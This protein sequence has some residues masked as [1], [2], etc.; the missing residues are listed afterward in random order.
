MFTNILGSLSYQLVAV[1]VDEGCWLQDDC[2]NVAI[3]LTS[4]HCHDKQSA[5][6][7]K[8]YEVVRF[9]IGS[10][11]ISMNVILT[12]LKI[13]V[14]LKASVFVYMSASSAYSS[15]FS[16]TLSFIYSK[17]FSLESS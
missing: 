11:Q 9:S 15:N 6:M 5:Q 8:K 1:E 2:N 4:K 3:K 12:G 16:R 13:T 17:L 7:A 10:A 14:L